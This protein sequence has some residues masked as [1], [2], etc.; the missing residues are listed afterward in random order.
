MNYLQ[1]NFFDIFK[2]FTHFKFSLKCTTAKQ[3]SFYPGF[4]V[5]LSRSTFTPKRCLGT[6]ALLILVHSAP[7]HTDFRATIRSTWAKGPHFKLVFLIGRSTSTD[8]N[9]QVQNEASKSNDILHYNLPDL[10]HHLTTKHVF[11]YRYG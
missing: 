2:P 8:V 1:Y 6:E 3:C 4:D 5:A 9:L 7:D 10:Y 11:G